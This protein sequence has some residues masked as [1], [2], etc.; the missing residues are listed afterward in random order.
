MWLKDAAS[1]V[2]MIFWWWCLAFLYISVCTNACA[3]LRF[4]LVVARISWV[5]VV[6]CSWRDDITRSLSLVNVAVIL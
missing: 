2:K 1:L 6:Q 4:G 5:E 3:D